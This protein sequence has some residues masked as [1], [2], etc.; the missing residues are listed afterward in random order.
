MTIKTEARIVSIS[1]KLWK[2]GWNGRYTVDHFDDLETDF[3]STHKRF[4]G[5]EILEATEDELS[6]LIEWWS[7]EVEAS[8][9]GIDGEGLRGLTAEQIEDGYEWVLFEEER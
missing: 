4:N 8:N 5:S 1:L 3:C 9:N 7:E 6:E 2:P